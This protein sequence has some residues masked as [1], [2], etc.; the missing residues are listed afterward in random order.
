MM[1]D[2][3]EPHRHTNP[4][5]QAEGDIPALLAAAARGDETAW[6]GIID[7]Y[8]RRVFALARSRLGAGG[9]GGAGGAGRGGKGNDTLAEEITQSVFAT[10]AAKLSP[11]QDGPAGYTEQGKFEAWLFRIAMN[12]VRDEVRRQRRHAVPTDPETLDGVHAAQG[13]DAAEH[14]EHRRQLDS[15]RAAMAELGEADREVIELRHHA[16][17]SFKQ[18]AELLAEPIGTLLAR[19][20]RALKK[21]KDLMS[22]PAS[23]SFGGDRS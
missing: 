22:S 19:H 8:A 17:L 12:R 20:H 13:E 4:T 14:A 11:R 15:L 21:L 5:R 7:L 9:S 23:I 3:R 6:R 1:D 16:G 10:L 2:A 18:I